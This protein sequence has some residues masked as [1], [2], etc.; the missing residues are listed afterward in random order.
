MATENRGLLKALQAVASG[1]L[2][3]AE[4]TPVVLSKA[5]DEL[6][7]QISRD[8]GIDYKELRDKYKQVI[9]K[10]HAT[11]PSVEP[12]CKAVTKRSKKPCTRYPVLNGYCSAHAEEM[13]RELETTGRQREVQAYQQ[14]VQHRVASNKL[15]AV[16]EDAMGNNTERPVMVEK[17][18]DPT[19]L[20]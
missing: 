10:N 6:L 15:D 13:R 18:E 2:Q 19:A 12:R 8:Y 1:S 20:L 5:I 14:K 11:M 9:V 16:W 4:F 3:V 17:V 7:F